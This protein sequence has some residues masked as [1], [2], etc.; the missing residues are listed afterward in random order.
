MEKTF[1]VFAAAFYKAKILFLWCPTSVFSKLHSPFPKASPHSSSFP[2]TLVASRGLSA[3][4]RGTWTEYLCSTGNSAIIVA[5][6][7][8]Q[9]EN[10]IYPAALLSQRRWGIRIYPEE[11][12]KWLPRVSSAGAAGDHCECWF[13]FPAEIRRGLR[14]KQEID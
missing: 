2:D 6:L 4:Q 12:C 9:S 14:N 10:I 7:W 13:P 8:I 5:L 1:S 3:A 11:S